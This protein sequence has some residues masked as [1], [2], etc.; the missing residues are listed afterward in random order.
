VRGFR[1][2]LNLPH[3]CQPWKL[4]AKSREHG[5]ESDA[6]ADH[7]VA[8]LS[9]GLALIAQPTCMVDAEEVIRFASPEFLSMLGRSADVVVGQTLRTVFGDNY[10][11]LVRGAVRRCLSGQSVQQDRPPHKGMLHQYWMRMQ[12]FPIARLADGTV[13]KASAVPGNSQESVC[14]LVLIYND[15]G[16]LKDREIEAAERERR[17]KH[18]TEAVG[19]PICYF[20][21]DQR[22]VMANGAICNSWLKKE[23]EV[24]GQTL[25]ECVGVENYNAVKRY[26]EQALQGEPVG[27]ERTVSYP[28][29]GERRIRTI[30]MP[31]T[32]AN[33]RVVGAFSVG[34][35]VEEDFQLKEALS[36]RERQLKKFTDNIP[37]AIAYVDADRKF[38]FVNDAYCRYRGL[39]RERIIGRTSEQ[40]FDPEALT[41]FEPHITKVRSGAATSYERLTPYPSGEKRWLRVSW[42]P[43]LDESGR[44]RG[45]YV[46]G[47]DI[48]ESK[49]AQERE[50]IRQRELAA[51]TD[52][53]PQSIA[54]IN[55]E[56]K[57][58]FANRNFLT[59]HGVTLDATI[60][61]SVDA[62]LGSEYRALVE[63]LRPELLKG[64]RQQTERLSPSQT[65]PRWHQ[66]QYVPR[67]NEQG[68]Y[69]GFYELSNDIHDLVA[70][71][72]DAIATAREFQR[73]VD[74]IPEPIAFVDERWT[75]GYAN[76]AFLH[77]V[78]KSREDLIGKT[79]KEALGEKV[80][81]EIAPYV[82]RAKRMESIEYERETVDSGGRRRVLHV[83]LIPIRDTSD[84]YN[85]H[86]VI[87]RDMTDIRLAQAAQLERSREAQRL[88]NSLPVPMAYVDADLVYRSVNPAY[89]EWVNRSA[90]E[91]IGRTAA[92][93]LSPAYYAAAKTYFTR[94]LGGERI[95]TDRLI[96]FR[97]R[98]ARW[99]RVFYLPQHDDNDRVIGFYFTA[100]DV[101]DL[102]VAEEAIQKATMLLENHIAN[103]PLAIV[104]CKRNFEIT[105]WSPQAQKLLGWRGREVLGKSAIDIGIFGDLTEQFASSLFFEQDNDQSLATRSIQAK[106]ESGATI[107]FEWY[108]SVL[109]ES[110]GEV[111]SML[112]MGQDVSERV[113]AE[114]QLQFLASHDTLTDLPN[115]RMFNDRLIEA[116]HRAKR[117]SS[118]FAVLFIDIDGF[119]AIND[120]FGH[121]VGDAVLIDCAQRIR[122]CLR[123]VDFAAR[124]SGDEFTVILEDVNSRDGVA[125]L[126]DRILVRIGGLKSASGVEV[127][128]SASIGATLYPDDGTDNDELLRR[129]DAAMYAAK[130]AG[131][132]CFVMYESTLN[133]DVTKR[134]R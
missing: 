83:R 84:Q 112:S 90:K 107:W 52:N 19:I 49:L 76:A 67:F 50:R 116:R 39:P 106:T 113:R 72:R 8:S 63:Q 108:H 114:E 97:D 78:G 75:Y 105:R 28:G 94:A 24:L 34:F 126:A 47:A 110:N 134:R 37:E 95:S 26:I 48:H 12:L 22:V 41:F 123:E 20:D 129:A 81:S 9:K 128:V 132:G 87:C 56:L 30:I 82:D 66:T 127:A 79:P 40:L 36:A 53:I 89:E 99:H 130:D 68:D 57:Y 124:I 25:E 42:I 4:F 111:I 5:L 10:Y 88:F 33:G 73:F 44:Y 14:G 122:S 131:K 1:R 92:E 109:R 31:E 64:E 125:T 13:C 58:E 102:K 80:S 74:N 104:E 98:P 96:L 71:Q 51:I 38:R 45:H 103:S 35:D 65:G 69:L 85:G 18:A 121:A 77:I 46:V 3:E 62:V 70:A 115:R 11:S 101:H 32:L 23:H 118:K 17:L 43:D 60:G 120:R 55:A 6:L 29:M 7:E 16:S 91:T 15:I 133:V 2:C 93:V 86:Y 100:Y 54:F 61:N 21:I 119:K 27:Y 117:S 59:T